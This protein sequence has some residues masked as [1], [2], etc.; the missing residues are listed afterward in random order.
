MNT[1]FIVILLVVALLNII[2]FFKVWG[3][4]NNVKSIM[5]FYIHEKGI[6]LID[7]GATK[8]HFKDKD[9]KRIEMM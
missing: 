3:M 9:G 8:E 1:F 2:L 5:S 4:N 7:D 6:R